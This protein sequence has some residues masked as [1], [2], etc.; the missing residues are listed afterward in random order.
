MSIRVRVHFDGK[1]IIPDEPV[2]LPVDEP[3]EADLH[4][5]SREGK[6]QDIARRLAAIE[7]IASRAVRG[8]NIPDEALRREN[9]YEDRI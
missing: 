1:A 4:V 3:I 7:R 9:M 8:T 6:E 2:D 5:L